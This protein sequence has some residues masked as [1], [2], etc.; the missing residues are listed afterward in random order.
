MQGEGIRIGPCATKK[1]RLEVAARSCSDDI[2]IDSQGTFPLEGNTV[3][4]IEYTDEVT[5]FKAMESRREKPTNLT[6][7]ITLRRKTIAGYGDRVWSE[8]PDHS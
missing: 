6:V 7:Q 2:L 4:D 5:M 3:S 1:T 8:G